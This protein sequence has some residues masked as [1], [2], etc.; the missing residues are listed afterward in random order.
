MSVFPQNLYFEA[1]T[2]VVMVLAGGAFQSGLGHAGRV[3]INGRSA[4]MKDP[5]ELPCPS[6]M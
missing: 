2:P 6:A 1:L 3:L 5:G 4:L